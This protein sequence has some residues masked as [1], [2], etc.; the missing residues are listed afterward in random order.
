MY[1]FQVKISCY[2]DDDDSGNDN[3]YVEAD[4]GDDGSGD[5]EHIMIIMRVIMV[6]I[7]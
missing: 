4:G 6:M 3:K 7:M 2:E 5:G 1:T